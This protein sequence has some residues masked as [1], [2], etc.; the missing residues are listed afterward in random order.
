MKV[1]IVISS[2]YV[3]GMERQM[4]YWASCMTNAGHEVF[5]YII[6]SNYQITNRKRVNISNDIVYPL[7]YNKYTK[8]ISQKLFKNYLNKH[9]PQ[10]IIAFQIG[11]IELCKQFK[12]ITKAN[13]ILIGTIRG[14]KFATN[15]ALSQRYREGVSDIDGL[16]CN[17]QKSLDLINK[18]ILFDRNLDCVNIPNIILVNKE[19]IIKKPSKWKILFA[20]T[21]KDVKDPMTFIKGMINVINLNSNVEILIAGDGPLKKRMFNKVRENNL[22]N[23]F[24]FLGFVESNEVPYHEA[25]I[26]VSTS[27][28][29]GSSN[30]ILEGL[31]NGCLVVGTNTGGTTE[32]LIDKPFGRLFEIGDAKV[33]SSVVCEFINLSESAYTNSV[34][35]GQKYILENH[36]INDVLMKIESFIS[37]IPTES[38]SVESIIN[39]NE[40]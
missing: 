20:G 23:Y 13:F 21:L 12:Q 38:K 29:E 17:S 40:L 2:T 36:N 32:L 11:A 6:G 19:I 34:V 16:I 33:L 14:I 4:A 5:V 1:G 35:M 30:T 37:R 9:K 28:R 27:L 10:V 26:V 24:K 22:Q 8:I 7:Y 39:V 31:A 18:H 25:N 3:G 15:S